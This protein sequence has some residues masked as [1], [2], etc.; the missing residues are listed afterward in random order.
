M[1]PI[2]S[3]LN[4]GASRR[5]IKIIIVKAILTVVA[6]IGIF[7]F[8]SKTDLSGKRALPPKVASSFTAKYA[9]ARIKKWEKRGD[10]YMLNFMNDERKCVA[11]YSFDGGW[12]R[13]EIS[14]PW[15]KDLP[16]PVQKSLQN[17]GYG[18]CYIDGIKEVL[19]AGRLFYVLHVDD[20]PSLDADH[21]DAF[22]QNY[23]L[24]FSQD[25]V[26]SEKQIQK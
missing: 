18:N 10:E 16:L 12:I 8:T 14:L 19:S 26:M 15:S 20:G 11:F 23:R 25:G 1:K 22:K 13:T 17:N 24:I 5:T 3:Q 4:Q 21:Y 6:V 9:N 2:I 7:S